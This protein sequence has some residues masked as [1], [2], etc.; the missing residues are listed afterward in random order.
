MARRLRKK[1][2]FSKKTLALCAGLC[3][4]CAPIAAGGEFLVS[5][6]PQFTKPFGE[7]H[8]IE[9]GMGAGLKAT[10]R[11]IKFLNLFAQGEYLSASLPGIAP[12]TILDA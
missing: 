11:P 1:N 12:I 10:Y 7:A 2:P 8:S 3:I 9:Y 6:F 4:S 5:V